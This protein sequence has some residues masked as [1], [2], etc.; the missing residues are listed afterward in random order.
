MILATL[1]RNR[2]SLFLAVIVLGQPACADGLTLFATAKVETPQQD[3][4]PKREHCYG[5]VL[6]SFGLN[7][8][9]NKDEAIRLG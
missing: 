8:Y 9:S 3:Q 4:V 1:K 7:Q 6:P 2:K 5:A